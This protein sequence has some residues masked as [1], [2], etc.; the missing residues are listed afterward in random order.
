MHECGHLIM[1]SPTIQ[2][3]FVSKTLIIMTV[4]SYDVFYMHVTS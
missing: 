3:I 2:H 4:D 1:S